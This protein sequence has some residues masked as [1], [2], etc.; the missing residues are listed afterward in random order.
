MSNSKLHL[1][2]LGRIEAE[3]YAEAP[4]LPYVLVLDN[5]R[6]GLN[7]GSLFRTADAYRIEEIM[8]CGITAT[9]P[10]KDIRK[11]ALGATDSVRWSHWDSTLDALTHLRSKGYNIASIEQAEHTVALH[12]FKPG[13]QPFALVLGNEVKGVSQEVVDASD[14]VIELPQF[15]TKHSLNVSVCGGIL[16]WEMW[17]KL[18]PEF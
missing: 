6:S 16:M 4:K 12:E 14:V 18:Q 3:A 2:E 1:E 7:V 13:L 17:R 11:T 15:G 10:Q 5:L 8:L 9:P